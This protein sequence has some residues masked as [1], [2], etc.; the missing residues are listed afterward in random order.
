MATRRRAWPSRKPRGVNACML[1]APTLDSHALPESI[2]GGVFIAGKGS[3]AD[4]SHHGRKLTGNYTHVTMAQSMSFCRLVAHPPVILLV[5]PAAQTYRQAQVSTRACDR[6]C[7][8]QVSSVAEQ[9]A[10]RHRSR[11]FRAAVRPLSA[12]G[13]T[14]TQRAHARKLARP[15]AEC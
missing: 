6:T 15:S 12:H 11:P 7:W 9:H 2:C 13:L 10:W 5:V 8:H 14:P 1:E 3:A 4:L